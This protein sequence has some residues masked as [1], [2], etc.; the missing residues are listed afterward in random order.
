M[1]S[2]YQNILILAM[3]LAVVSGSGIY[4]TLFSQPKEMERLERAEK[5]ARM[6]QAELS[7]L[8]AEATESEELA[9]N[10][11]NR[12]RARYKVVPKELGSEEVIRNLNDQTTSGFKR[13]DVTFQ[14]HIEEADFNTYVFDI[15]GRAFF[16]PFYRLIW[17]LENSRQF[18]RVSRLKLNH[19][20]LITTDPET[21]R[22]KLDIMVDF[23]FTLETYYAGI[24][25]LSA[26]DEFDL[27]V[28]LAGD[29]LPALLPDLTLLPDGILPSRRAAENPFRPLILGEIPPNTDGLLDIER[30]NLISIADSKA[31]FEEEGRFISVGV[32]DDIYLGQ[33]TALDPRL[34]TILARLNKGGIIDEVELILDT[35][36]RFRQAI[37]PVNLTPAKTN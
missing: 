34:G 36:E 11:I 25:G 26:T 28:E 7:A 24:D 8:M 23:S 20:D 19:I 17:D 4:I 37:G 33:I 21:S 10:V 30:A 15:N 3:C 18:Y 14:D 35:G 31:I 32:G 16:N 9:R 2:V 12:W 5:V 13:F 29:A 27:G 22:E 1:A 6:K